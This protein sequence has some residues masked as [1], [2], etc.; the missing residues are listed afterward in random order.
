[1]NARD[2]DR[3]RFLKGGALAAFSLPFLRILPS[4]A[5]AAQYPKRLVFFC[6]PNGTVMDDWWNGTGCGYGRIL[7]SL[8]PLQS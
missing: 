4:S 1:M 7:D 3:R 5:A 6:T 2:F 8:K